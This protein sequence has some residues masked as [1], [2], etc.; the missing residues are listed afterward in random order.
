MRR[1]QD[2]LLIG[3]FTLLVIHGYKLVGRILCLC[4]KH[5]TVLITKPSCSYLLVN[6]VSKIRKMMLNKDVKCLWTKGIHHDGP[7]V[8]PLGSIDS[9]GGVLSEGY[10]KTDIPISSDRITLLSNATLLVFRSVISL[11]NVQPS[12][13]R[14]FDLLKLRCQLGV[15]VDFNFETTA[16]IPHDG[17]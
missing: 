13:F 12:S 9:R 2:I 11:E 6:F 5:C 10:L 15:R 4:S 8:F 3:C 1:R 16:T 7:I 17:S 14:W